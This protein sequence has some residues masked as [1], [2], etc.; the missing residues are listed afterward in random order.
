MTPFCD[1]GTPRTRACPR[2]F[3]ACLR[4][5]AGGT[6]GG[7][8]HEP[9]GRSG[10]LR[11]CRLRI[12]SALSRLLTRPV[13]LTGATYVVFFMSTG[14]LTPFWPLWLAD[15]GLTPEEVGLY[16]ALGVA[17]RVVA[18]HG[19]PVA[20]RPSR[21]APADAR[22]L[23]LRDAPA[24]PL[25]PRHRARSRRFSSPPSRSAPP[26]P[27][28][29][30]LA[31]ALGIAASRAWRFPYAPVRGVGS[32][33]YLVANLLV[34]ALIA[35]TGSWVALWWMVGCMAAARPALA[36]PSGRRQG[37]PARRRA[38]ARSAGWW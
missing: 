11:P 20:G 33:G 27:G 4:A 30:P 17:V 15:W 37:Q 9:A 34:G 1:A 10:P 14:V 25:A 16:T 7:T 6:G 26:W 3:R 22:R 21:P 28:M 5:R 19:G 36:R 12:L 31:E 2:Q 8:P 29:G 24:L 13:L 35:A 38:S 32:A 18:G 23:R